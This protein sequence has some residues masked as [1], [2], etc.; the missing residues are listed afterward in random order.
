MTYAKAIEIALS[1]IDATTSDYDTT[2]YPSII[3]TAQKL[4][5][6]QG[7]HI[8]RMHTIVKPSEEETTYILP[9]LITG[10]Y[11]LVNVKERGTV[12]PVNYYEYGEGADFTI[13]ITGIGTFDIYYYAMPETID[14]DT[15]DTYKFEVSD[16]THNAIP[17]YLG[18]ELTKIDDPTTAQIMSNQWDKYMS[19]FTDKMKADKKMIRNHYEV[20]NGYTI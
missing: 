18:Y 15:P 12:S 9:T 2:I 6:T 11:E 5:A 16:E 4:I 7:R 19:L 13:S 20:R 1:L 8:K 14:G 10:F 3:D 17:Y